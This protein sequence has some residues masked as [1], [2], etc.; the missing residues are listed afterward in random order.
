MKHPFDVHVGARIRQSRCN[1]KLSKKELGLILGVSTRQIQA[2]ETGVM[3]VDSQL[4]RRVVDVL[5]AP[6]TFYFEG[7]ATSLRSAA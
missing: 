3:K 2:L 1:S 4:M 6:A 5:D 7:L